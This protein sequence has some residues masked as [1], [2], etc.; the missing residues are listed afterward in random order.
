MPERQ[1]GF[2]E[3]GKGMVTAMFN[4]FRGHDLTSGGMWRR[5]QR[6]LPW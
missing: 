2:L 1:K 5:L 4:N 6:M 3:K